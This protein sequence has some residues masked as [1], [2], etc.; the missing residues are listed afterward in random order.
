MSDISIERDGRIAVVRFD[1]GVKANPLSLSVMRDLTEVARGFE[2]DHELSAVVLA[3]GAENFCLGFDLKDAENARLRDA[4]L[5]ERREALKT[6]ARMCRAW[7]EIEALTITSVDG[8]CVGGG[9]ALAV[10]TDLRVAS[11]N[12]RFYVPEIERGMNMSWGSVPRIA[13]LVGPA[14][15]KRLVALAETVD[16]A[17]AVEWGLA[18]EAADDAMAAAM[19]FAE[20]AAAMPPVALRMCKRAVDAYAGALAETASWADAD[21]FALAQTGEDYAEGVASFIEGRAPK[22]TGR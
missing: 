9:V 7:A 11:T 1:R 19:A 5:A 6:G 4:G 10:S 13:N 14:K 2:G 15:A 12:A 22:F 16:A 21:Q 18:D 20:R 17:M 3:G 8:W